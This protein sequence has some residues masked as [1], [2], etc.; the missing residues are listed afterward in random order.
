MKNQLEPTNLKVKIFK[1]NQ[2]ASVKTGK[3]RKNQLSNQTASLAAG[4]FINIH[5][6]KSN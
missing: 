6:N 3:V 5:G 2:P 4:S 1:R